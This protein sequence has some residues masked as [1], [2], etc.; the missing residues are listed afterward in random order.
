[1]TAGG[2]L[3]VVLLAGQLGAADLGGL[4][5]AEVV[6]APMTLVGEA[7]SF[8]GIPILSRALAISMAFAR[9]WAWQLGFGAAA[10]V[11]LYLAI[12]FPLRVQILTRVFGQDFAR[13]AV[14]ALPT[15]LAQLL[16]AGSP[17]FSV[18]IKAAARVHAIVV[19]RALTTGFTLLL[20]PLLAA[21]YGLTP[22]VWGLAI[23]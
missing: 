22:A 13:F 19:V 12:A 14:L 21:L 4:R 17:A 2:E 10:L 5:S 8:P 1:L 6:F 7:L 16:R 18:L 23:G 9:R 15:A 3:T 11:G 20:G